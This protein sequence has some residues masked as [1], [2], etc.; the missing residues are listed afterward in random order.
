[1]KKKIQLMTVVLLV[2]LVGVA[3]TVCANGAQENDASDEAGAYKFAW[4]GTSNVDESMQWFMKNA[5]TKAEELG[6]KM[7]VF[8]PSGDVQR[9]ANMVNDA[10]ASGC[11]AIIMQALDREALIPALKKA[12][13]AGVA[14][15]LFGGD[16]APMG[17][18]YRDLFAGPDDLEAGERAAKAIMEAFPDGAKGVMIMGGPG[19]DPMV[20]R[21]TGFEETI[22]GTNIELLGKQACEGWDPAKALINMEDFITKFGDEI[23]YVYSHWDNGSTAIVQAIEAAGMDGIFIVSVDGCREGF[24]LVN[25]GRIASTIYQDMAGQ[26]F[27]AVQGAYDVLEGKSVEPI[28][29]VPWTTITKENADFDP[30]W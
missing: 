12:H 19:E 27:K 10:V 1:M 14:I 13:D 5:Q 22:K 16:I 4:I 28:N 8:D 7:V 24:K 21:E 30:G 2:L 20:K 11:D 6:V 29:F 15:A 3:G 26:S 23:Q 17:Q 9:Q 25:E 18:Q